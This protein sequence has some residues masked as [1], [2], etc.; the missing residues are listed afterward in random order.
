M[1]SGTA[2]VGS[3]YDSVCG[4]SWLASKMGTEVL[5]AYSMGMVRYVNFTLSV[6]IL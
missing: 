3:V 5:T 2:V 6:F 1:S 4:L